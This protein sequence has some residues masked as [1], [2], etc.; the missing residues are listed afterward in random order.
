MVRSL[1][2]AASGMNAQQLNVDTI[3]NNLAN[4]NTAGYKKE[5]TNF[6]SLIY[7]NIKGPDDEVINEYTP[8]VRQVGHGVRALPNSRNF[9]E[10]NLQET[11]NPQDVAI[12][13]KGFFAIDNNGEELY[14]RDG[15]FAYA[16][17][18]DGAGYA[19]ITSDGYPIMS[20]DDEAIIVENDIP[21]DSLQI[22]GTGR[23]FYY[24]ENNEEIEVGQ[25]KLVQFSNRAGLE[26]IG[27]NLYRSTPASGDPIN[28]IDNED[29]TQSTLRTKYLESSNVELANEIVNLIIAQRVYEVN[30]TAIKTADDMWKQANQ[31]KQ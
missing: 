23:I 14:T 20:I 31:L 7:A 12:I 15:S 9:T 27:S 26:S 18:E 28:E 8:T 6:K 2:T 1:Y 16:M 3:S 13:G 17:L 25:I 24:D 11:G 22:E 30:S 10:G 5:T 19:L 4:V 21:V 29:L